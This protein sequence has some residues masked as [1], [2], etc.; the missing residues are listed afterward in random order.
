MA[1]RFSGWKADDGSIWPTEDA[2]KEH[3]LAIGLKLILKDYP[4]HS[5]LDRQVQWLMQHPRLYIQLLP[6]DEGATK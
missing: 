5:L 2:A 4:V 3:E 1:E 6:A